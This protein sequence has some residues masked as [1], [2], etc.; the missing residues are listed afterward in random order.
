MKKRLILGAAAVA[1]VAALFTALAIADSGSITDPSGD[2]KN[3]QGKPT[4]KPS[5][6]I[7]KATWGHAKHG[8]L[9]HSV[10]VAGKVG[11][12][13]AQGPTGPLPV[14]LIDVPKKHFTPGCDYS[15]GEVLPGT[16]GNNSNKTKWLVRKC[17]NGPT[18]KTTGIAKATQPSSDTITLTFKKKAIG[19]PR[20]YGWAFQFVEDSN[21]GF[22]L[23]DR[24][25]DT[26]FK[27]H[28]L[29]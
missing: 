14:L 13:N 3:V 15:V 10:T 8:G 28:R 26:G 11:D 20:R 7:I 23:V 12:P 19:K 5:D 21:Q 27:V 16:P 4:H 18:Q 24:A 9:V 6:D 22:Y 2:T 1:V 25:P 29:H 17:S